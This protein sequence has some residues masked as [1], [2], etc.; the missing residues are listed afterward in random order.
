[1]KRAWLFIF[2][3]VIALSIAIYSKR[4]PEILVKNSGPA[5]KTFVKN[6]DL[7]VST[8]KT[9]QKELE[10]ARVALPKREIAQADKEEAPKNQDTPPK[11]NHFLMRENRVLI[12]DIQKNN[13][14]DPDVELE[15]LNKINPDWKDILGH[16]L[17]RFQD[18]DTKVLIKEEFP[19][20]QIKNGKGFYSEQVIITY[21]LKDG[22][23]NSFRALIDSDTGS[24]T[25]T[26]DRTIHERFKKEGA[27][28]SL[29]TENNSG[30]IAR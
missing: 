10:A 26:W 25:D 23:V 21:V 18:E 24:I 6:A 8:Y 11:D 19:I 27:G 16:E 2:S 20:I 14:Q 22:S 7:E 1:M 15:M 17:L 29:P 4:S 9:T 30:I 13:Y 5:W 12:G 28:L 3:T